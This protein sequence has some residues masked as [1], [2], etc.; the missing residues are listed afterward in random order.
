MAL[1]IYMKLGG[2][3]VKHPHVVVSELDVIELSPLY[4][5]PIYSMSK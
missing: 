5:M 3:L 2:V 1:N 4:R